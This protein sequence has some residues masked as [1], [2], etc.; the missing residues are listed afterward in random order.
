MGLNILMTHLAMLQGLWGFAAGRY[1]LLAWG[2][3]GIHPVYVGI[4]L[5]SLS[6][7]PLIY[8]GLGK[9]GLSG[10][11]LGFFVCFCVIV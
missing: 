6:P 4:A 3:N 10:V 2:F 1:R 8:K 7:H 9:T 5:S 11:L